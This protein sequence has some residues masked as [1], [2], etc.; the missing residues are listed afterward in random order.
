MNVIDIV[1]FAVLGIST[2][3]G[4]YYGF[5]HTIGS[6][7]AILLSILLSFSVGPAISDALMGNASI[8]ESLASVTDAFVRVGD[9]DLANTPVAELKD[10]VTD[11]IMHSVQLPDSLSEILRS[12]LENQSFASQNIY[13]VN[14]Y[15][16]QTIVNA[17]IHVLG[18]II[19]FILIYIIF[20]I[21]LNLIRHVFTFPVLRQL[22]TLFGG[23]FGLA[24]G[25]AIVMVLALL[26]PL[27]DTVI[28]ENAMA[29][30]IAGSKMFPWF[31]NLR[32]FLK[33]AAGF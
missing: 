16:S 32:I 33:V 1:I 5:V 26:V 10:T 2:I 27:I 23:V 11:T 31:E 17:G 24:R 21:I 18:F 12:N 25:A 15:V 30:V 6:F 29:S 3:Y 4:L 20:S 13:T 7:V 8:S 19:S 9:W 28:P 22:D 14:E